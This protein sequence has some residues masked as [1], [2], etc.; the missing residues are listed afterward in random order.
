VIQTLLIAAGTLLVVGATAS[1]QALVLERRLG[2]RSTVSWP[3][4]WGTSLAT[5][6]LA[7]HVTALVLP[8][9][10]AV[11]LT[12]LGSLVLAAVL[13]WRRWVAGAS[14][15]R[16]TL[17]G[18]FGRVLAPAAGIVAAVLFIWPSLAWFD[19]FDSFDRI[20]GHAGISLEIANGVYPPRNMSLPS[21]PF[22]Y[23]YGV[24]VYF[25]AAQVF[26]GARI[27]HAIDGVTLALWLV[28]LGLAYLVGRALWSARVGTAFAILLG[29]GGGFPWLLQGAARLWFN[30][31]G[32]PSTRAE[33]W[34]QGVFQYRVT[35]GPVASWRDP[36]GDPPF[37]NDFFQHPWDL[38]APLL[39]ATIPLVAVVVR[40][41][42]SSDSRRGVFL[43]FCLV[44]LLTGLSLA[45]TIAFFLALAGVLALSLLSALR[46]EPTTAVRLAAVAVAAALCALALPDLASTTM[47]DVLSG[48]PGLGGL[49]PHVTSTGLVHLVSIPSGYVF[50]GKIGWNLA[51]FGFLL[52]G[53]GVLLRRGVRST[54]WGAY[55][56]VVAILGFAISNAFYYERSW[57]IVKFAT[58]SRIGLALGIAAT[59]QRD[60]RRRRSFW[61]RHPLVRLLVAGGIVVSGL[62]HQVSLFLPDPAID[63]AI[64]SSRGLLAGVTPDELHA[65]GWLR[66]RIRT[67][68]TVVCPA[69]IDVAC[70]ALGGLPQ[71]RL[72]YGGESL[73]YRPQAL[74]ELQR[75][76]SAQSVSREE[77]QTDRFCW[78][79]VSPGRTIAYAGLAHLAE[80][81][82]TV[83]NSGA[84]LVVRLC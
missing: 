84:V 8:I 69:Q 1:W 15:V 58:V 53:F 75:L 40:T 16:R 63:R 6:L 35:A 10:A 76:Q 62:L 80:A 77:A 54:P 65:I 55:V 81:S 64:G 60:T 51:T 59:F 24:D 36:R 28:T 52:V 49:A 21:E 72:D 25:A 37:V 61:N 41:S 57:D 26:S 19:Y 23:H 27:D 43:A 46:R 82:P 3:I 38:G 11:F 39:L 70:A 42:R 31:Y 7:L 83:F 45:H 71:P 33:S 12:I 78:A 9:R 30:G 18:D 48:L 2:L 73:L 17:T 44:V 20:T 32:L 5:L 79:I 66:G 22:I 50:A 4:A 68:E 13:A 74:A 34:L 14:A 56:L 67:G 29:A 47:R